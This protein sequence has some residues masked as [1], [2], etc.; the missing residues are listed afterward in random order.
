[1]FN[2]T[3]FVD[4]TPPVT[5]IK[6]NGPKQQTILSPNAQLQLSA[7]DHQSGVRHIFYMLDNGDSLEYSEVISIQ[8]LEDGEHQIQYWGINQVLIEE[9]K[10]VYAF[11]LD[12]TPPELTFEILGPQN[13]NELTTY[14][15]GSS[16]IQL[17][18]TDKKAGL[19]NIQIQIDRG[20][21]QSYQHPISLH[22]KSGLRR[23]AYSAIDSVDNETEK[24]LRKIYVDLTPPQTFHEL[25]GSVLAVGDTLVINSETE[26]MLSSM[27]L[28]SGIHEIRFN[29][30]EDSDRVYQHPVCLEGE[31]DY[32]LQYF[33][34]DQVKNREDMHNLLLRVDN[35]PRRAVTEAPLSMHP[36]QWLANDSD[37]PTG[38]T[39]LPFYLRIATG[40][41]ES[42]ESFLIDPATVKTE[43]TQP[44]LFDQEGLN[45]LTMQLVGKEVMYEIPIDGKPPTTQI[46]FEGARTSQTGNRIFYGPGLVISLDPQDPLSTIQS[47]LDKVYFSIDGSAFGLYREQLT[48][49]TRE[50]E[51][52]I[53]Y[54]SVDRVGNA[55]ELHE[56][57]FT[58]DTAPPRTR[59]AVGGRYY[60]NMLSSNSEITLTASD[61]LSEVESVFYRIDEQSAKQYSKPITQSDLSQL[62]PGEHTV[63]YYAIDAVGNTEEER[64]FVFYFDPDPPV[65]I[66]HVQGDQSKAEETYVSLRTQF[67]LTADETANEVKSIT[68]HINDSN[69]KQYAEPFALPSSERQYNMTFYG[70]DQIDNTSPR[71]TR[72][73]TVDMTSPE[74]QYTYEGPIF[75]DGSQV[76]I[77]PGT[78]I[79]LS[80]TDNTSGMKVTRYRLDQQSWKNYSDPLSIRSLGKHRLAFFSKD[81]VNNEE[82]RQTVNFFVDSRPPKIS[83]M[84]SVLP[85]STNESGVLEI[86]SSASI[87]ISAEDEHTGID[88]ITYSI[89]GGDERLYRTPITGFEKGSRIILLVTATDRV[90]NME[91]SRIIYRFGSIE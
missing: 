70:S 41:E 13:K 89:N 30:N 21:V 84:T 6:V 33:G 45:Q 82:K 69:A 9:E 3:F 32:T 73:F 35:M 42:A 61:H 7:A 10:Q 20:E 31:G 88:K 76:Y 47:G 66:L 55:E 25:K 67:A 22:D 68:Y 17:S 34:I 29:V 28:E 78:K 63:I 91:V 14:V 51:Y 83:I 75:S 12:K 81:R 4:V 52:R 1:V 39:A 15:S 65:V 62:Q 8:D 85:K 5:Q 53:R 49:F 50:K 58:I 64:S 36:K 24:F 43:D 80:A 11:C 18:G 37:N 57:I 59:L 46:I 44:L 86:P 16:T 56:S 87:Y 60:G 26:I 79:V 27:D 90:G 74:T 38:S 19:N 23:I 40:P 2:N 54:Y 48:L 71:Q 72:T 77:G